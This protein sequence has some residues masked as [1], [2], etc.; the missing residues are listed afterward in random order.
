MRRIRIASLFTYLAI[1]GDEMRTLAFARNVDRERFDHLVITLRQPDA[2]TEDRAG[3]MAG[4]LA[5]AGSAVHALGVRWSGAARRFALTRHLLRAGSVVARLARLLRALKVDVLD[6]RMDYAM[7][8]GLPAARLAGTKIAI[9]TEYLN[10]LWLRP[11]WRRI[12]PALFNGFDALVTDSRWV[13]A[14]YERELGRRLARAHVVQNGIDRPVPG[15]DRGAVRARLGIPADARV[16]AQVSRIAPFKGHDVLVEAAREVVAAAPDVHFLFCGYPGEHVEH[17]RRLAARIDA[18]GLAPR[19]HLASWPG[20]I[21]DV[22]SAVDVHVHASRFDSS[23]IAIH[24]SMALGLPL[25]AT[26]VGGI[27]ELVEDGRT[28]ILVPPDDPRALAT[29]LRRVLGDE[30]EAARLGAGARARWQARHRPEVMTRALERLMIELLA[31]RG[32]SNDRGSI[33][34]APNK[35]NEGIG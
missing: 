21:A 34:W 9:A 13:I 10:P 16:V 4:R 22:W 20:S 1:G 8:V 14:A 6:A 23:P 2:A 27:P 5:A 25:V 26:A 19:V 28:G 31:K 32:A 24:E 3:P 33:A 35:G 17:H 12:A 18:L 30:V 15:L 11:P 7:F 29:A